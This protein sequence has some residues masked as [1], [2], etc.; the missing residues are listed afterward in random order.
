MYLLF[1]GPFGTDNDIIKLAT[2]P[3]IPAIRR[4]Y[5]QSGSKVT[6]KWS[7]SAPKVTFICQKVVPRWPQSDSNLTPDLYKIIKICVKNEWFLKTD[8]RIPK[9]TAQSL[10]SNHQVTSSHPQISKLTSKWARNCLKVT[11]KWPQNG[12]FGT[13]KSQFWRLWYPNVAISTTF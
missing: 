2:T 9:V 11:S 4:L 12:S 10:Q 13:P 5:A 8:L 6:P 3:I 1:M 7:Q